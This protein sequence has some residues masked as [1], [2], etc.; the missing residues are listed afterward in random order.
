VKQRRN[1]TPNPSLEVST[2]GWAAAGAGTTLSRE[3]EGVD[4][5][6]CARLS[7]AG[8]G[9][10]GYLRTV[11]GAIPAAPGDVFTVSCYVKGSTTALVGVGVRWLNASNGVISADTANVGAPSASYQRIS[12][13]LAPA[14]DLTAQLQ[15]QFSTN[16]GFGDGDI[17]DLDRF[18][19]EQVDALGGYFDGATRDPATPKWVPSWEGE[20]HLSP[21]RLTYDTVLSSGVRQMHVADRKPTQT[22]GEVGDMWFY[23][24]G[25]TP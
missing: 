9:A 1:H 13:V 14:P 21:S 20:E 2:V 15:I 3:N 24:Q 23:V 7:H 8:A 19:V 22:D 18:M 4:G 5:G 12:R 6:W 16:A 10:A 11:N 17:I 25:A